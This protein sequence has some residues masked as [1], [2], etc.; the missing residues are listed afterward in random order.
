[1]KFGT[2]EKHGPVEYWLVE[3]PGYGLAFVCAHC[4]E[5]RGLKEYKS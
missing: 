1:M 2:C 4:A 5:N 3:I